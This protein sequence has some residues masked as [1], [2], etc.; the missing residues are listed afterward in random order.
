MK[1][2]KEVFSV[3]LETNP[4]N[5]PN[6]NDINIVLNDK[7][8]FIKEKSEKTNSFIL[9]M[10]LLAIL[11]TQFVSYVCMPIKSIDDVMTIF[12]ICH[13]RIINKQH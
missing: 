13:M 7:P 5:K 8:M 10:A 2:K 9:A 4:D 3:V 1:A 11:G 12:L 6:K